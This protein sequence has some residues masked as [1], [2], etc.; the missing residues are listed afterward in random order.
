MDETD[1]EG[2]RLAKLF[3]LLTVNENMLETKPRVSNNQLA[4][5]ADRTLP[6]ELS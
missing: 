6:P 2:I 5:L 1:G 4:S 3:Q